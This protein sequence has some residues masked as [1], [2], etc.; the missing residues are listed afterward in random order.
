MPFIT[1]EG[2]EGS[3]KSTQLARAAVKLRETGREVFDTREPG[4]TAIGRKIREILMDVSH[5]HLDP[6]AEWLLLEADRR[7]HVVEAIRPALA[8]GVFVLCDRYSDSTTA[9][10]AAGRGL[11]AEG[12]EFV[13]AIARDGLAPDLTL[14]YDVMPGEGLARARSRDGGTGRFEAADAAF[15]ERVRLAYLE[16]ARRRPERVR[17]L[18]AAGTPDEVFRSTW[19]AL[20]RAF[21]L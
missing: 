8:R 1:F 5:A 3:G 7:Q 14:L 9:Y 20:T 4:G 12:V 6:A 10:Q 15:H 18:P 2:V 21:P 17:V 19:A 13:D 11:D 16:I